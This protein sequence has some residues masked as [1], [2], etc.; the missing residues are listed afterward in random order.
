MNIMLVS[1]TE[2]TR[3]IGIRRALGASQNNI[4]IQFLLE[5]LVLTSLGGLLGIALGSFAAGMIGKYSDLP[6]VVTTHS[7][8]T[9]FA[10]AVIVGII[11]GLHPA[12]KAAK[13]QPIDALRYE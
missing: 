6:I 12:R 3:E 2:R 8:I 13:L 10:F 11:F 9:A 7:I 5:A 1:V 4:L